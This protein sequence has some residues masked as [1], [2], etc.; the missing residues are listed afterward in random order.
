MLNFVLQL[1][2]EKQCLW[3]KASG[4]F[5]CP[6]CNQGVMKYDPYCYI[7]KKPS[8]NFYVHEDCRKD[9]YIEQ[10]VVFTRYRQSKAQRLLKH[11]KYY[12]K[13]TAY[14]DIILSN[15]NF[16]QKYVSKENSVFVPV[17]MNFLRRWKR[18]YN[19]SEKIVEY[20]SQICEIPVN[21]NLVIRS[22]FTKQQ[23]KLS[24]E[25]RKNN[26]QNSFSLKIGQIIDKDTIIY[27]VDDI[28]STGAT[29]H[30]FAKL[31]Y[32]NGYK[33]IRVVALA[34]D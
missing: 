23:S 22:R 16:F 14:W 10:V 32:Q 5:F 29:V 7:C 11:A 1:F 13:H 25:K 27:I 6:K 33:K 28:I 3:C 24:A 20:L 2:T 26:L 18:W 19:Q 12:K 21:D 30:E 31:L 4:R 8:D 15:S 9:F 34:S 17:P